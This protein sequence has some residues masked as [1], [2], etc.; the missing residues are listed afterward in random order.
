L[1]LGRLPTLGDEFE[2]NKLARET[3]RR[4]RE[5]TEQGYRMGGIAPYGYR[6]Q[7]Q[8]LPV[9]HGGDTDKSCVT[10]EPVPHQAAVV[11][12]IFHLHADKGWSPNLFG[13]SAGWLAGQA[14]TVS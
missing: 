2:R 11:T 10:L 3:K 8:A 5:A 4:M 1:A 9:G 13:K 6:R 14:A 12:E 7:L